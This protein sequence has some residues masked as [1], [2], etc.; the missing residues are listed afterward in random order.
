MSRKI[1]HAIAFALLCVA[2]SSAHAADRKQP[3]S[4]CVDLAPERQMAR[5]GSQYLLVKDGQAHYRVGFGGDCSAI[6]LS[7]QIWIRTG[8]QDNRLC[9]SGTRVLSK[10]DSCTVR[11]VVPIS[12]DDYD[13]YAR[14]P[15]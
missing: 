6:S 4:D 8:D 3:L 2:A 5:F 14:R 13:S 15:R 11:S 9:P 12:R 7:T 1:K 10:R